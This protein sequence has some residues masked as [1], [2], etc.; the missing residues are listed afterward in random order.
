MSIQ[1]VNK[2]VEDLINSTPILEKK[3]KKKRE[4]KKR[5]VNAYLINNSKG[6]CVCVG[7]HS[8]KQ[9]EGLDGVVWVYTN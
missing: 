3:K 4:K 6:V 1:L 9:S 7:G 2:A 8:H 5:A